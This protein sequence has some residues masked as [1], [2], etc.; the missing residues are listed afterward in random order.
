MQLA[1]RRDEPVICES[2]KRRIARKM[3]GQRFCS[4]RC[5][6]RG[7]RRSRKR[8]LSRDTR[9]PATPIK[10]ARGFNELEGAKKRSSGANVNRARVIQIECFDPHHWQTV[11]S[12]DGVTVEVA[13][14]RKK[15][16]Y[17]EGARPARGA[18]R[19]WRGMAGHCQNNVHSLDSR[20]SVEANNLIKS[21][22]I[23]AR[24]KHH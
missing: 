18:R 15:L 24:A 10:T 16:G 20:L 9:A 2:C 8:F 6:D 12:P 7:R 22:G 14:L 21:I 1:S 17:S 23:T 13:Q 19:Q 5:R 4:A 11:T 3:R